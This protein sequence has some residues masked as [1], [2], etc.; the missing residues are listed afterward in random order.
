MNDKKGLHP[1][2]IYPQPSCY[3]FNLEPGS[4]YVVQVDL[5]LVILCQPLSIWDCSPVSLGPA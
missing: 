5:E 4:H 1:W 2:V 3:I